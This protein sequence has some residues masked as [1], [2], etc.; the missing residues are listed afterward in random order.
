MPQLLA[1]CGVF[2]CLSVLP[3]HANIG[4]TIGFVQDIKGDVVHIIGDALTDYG[5]RDAFVA[6]GDAPVYDLLT[7]KRACAT[8]IEQNMDIRMAYR[9]ANTSGRN[10]PF[11]AI[12]VWLNWGY[13]DA[14]VFTVAVSENINF[15]ANGTVF[16]C[17]DGKYR[18]VIDAE[19]MVY[20]PISGLLSPLDIVPGMEFFVWVDMITASTPALVYPDKIVVVR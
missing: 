13:D 2:I 9:V 3:V 7:G 17:T 12:A 14:A 18:I 16:L 15:D 11:S 4:E 19:T 6:I 8:Q 5:L 10:E 20:D 1:L